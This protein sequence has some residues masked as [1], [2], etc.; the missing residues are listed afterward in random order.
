[1]RSTAAT[2]MA[3]VRVQPVLMGARAR[4]MRRIRRAVLIVSMLSLAACEPHPIGD[5]S[6]TIFR[7]ELAIRNDSN[8]VTYLVIGSPGPPDV[9]A[10]EP[11]SIAPGDS[12]TVNV[13]GAE[14]KVDPPGGCFENEQVWVIRSR[15]GTEY[16]FA[17]DLAAQPADVEVL[18]FF[19][20]ETCTDQE[21][22]EYV[23]SG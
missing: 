10:G 20:P 21:V 19:P 14:A 23:W 18:K 11:F 3:R 9:V 6:H 17:D 8:E 16:V 12:D 1:M 4:A 22:L 7:F 5:E 2:T 13:G 15:S